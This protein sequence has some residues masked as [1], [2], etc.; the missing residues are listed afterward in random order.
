ME[1]MSLKALKILDCAF[2]GVNSIPIELLAVESVEEK[3]RTD[4][5]GHTQDQRVKRQ[6]NLYIIIHTY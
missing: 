3:G 1:Y 5:H 2:K 6:K 4:K